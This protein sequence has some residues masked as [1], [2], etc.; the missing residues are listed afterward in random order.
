MQNYE[1]DLIYPSIL[2]FSYYFLHFACVYAEKVVSLHD[3][4]KCTIKYWKLII[5]I[6]YKT[7]NHYGKK[8]NSILPCLSRH[9]AE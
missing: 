7:K 3:N 2:K 1:K 4:C 5:K 6:P 9:V 8:R